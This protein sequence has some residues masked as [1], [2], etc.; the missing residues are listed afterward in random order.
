M[1]NKENIKRYVFGG[2]GQF[3]LK[4]NKTD[5]SYTYRISKPKDNDEILYVSAYG[6]DGGGY[7]GLLNIE[8]VQYVHTKKAKLDI[9]HDAVKG[10]NWLIKQFHN[11]LEFNDMMEFY[12]MGVCCS[13]G[14]TLTVRDNIEMGIG[15]ICFKNY[16][17]NNKRA[18]RV[19][20]IKELQK[21]I[22]NKN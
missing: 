8:K 16:G 17:K 11:D 5:K 4:S 12:H 7:I 9:N 10:I 2:R 14:R 19:K 21:K 20:K 18:N 13:C 22:R 15:P 1:T 6:L 3:L